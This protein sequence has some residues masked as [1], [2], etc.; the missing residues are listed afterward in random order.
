M[1]SRHPTLADVRRQ[2]GR[3]GDAVARWGDDN[4]ATIHELTKFY[5]M[6][7][8]YEARGKVYRP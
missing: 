3:Y 6:R 8:A 2:H 7:D 4:G 1:S 5:A